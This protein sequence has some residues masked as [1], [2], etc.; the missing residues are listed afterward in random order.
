MTM[1]QEEGVDKYKNV[2]QTYLS[3]KDKKNIK[4][5]KNPVQYELFKIAM[6]IVQKI[7]KKESLTIYQV[8]DLLQ[9]A[10]NKP[11][12]EKRKSKPETDLDKEAKLLGKYINVNNGQENNKS[13]GK[14]RGSQISAVS[15]NKK[16]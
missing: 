7:E 9:N 13:G 11:Q 15:Q 1:S 5:P 10:N 2:R 14:K 8:V 16:P 4:L 6:H 3:W 12:G